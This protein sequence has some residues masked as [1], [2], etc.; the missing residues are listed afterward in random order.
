MEQARRFRIALVIYA[1]LAILIWTT[2]DSTSVPVAGGQVSLRGVTLAVLAFFVVRT[3][4]H[5]KAQQIRG[6]N[7]QQ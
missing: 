3:V 4:L 6:Q 5:W 7:E 2:M 1:A